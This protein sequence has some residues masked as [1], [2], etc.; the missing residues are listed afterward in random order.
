MGADVPGSTS[1]YSCKGPRAPRPH[2][3]GEEGRAINPY[4]HLG[5]GSAARA[6]GLLC[7][8]K[9]AVVNA[10]RSAA[11]VLLASNR[12]DIKGIKWAYMYEAI[13]GDIWDWPSAQ[14]LCFR[15]LVV[16]RSSTIDYHTHLRKPTKKTA[17]GLAR[18]ARHR[19]IA[20]A[21]FK[22]FL[23]SLERERRRASRALGQPEWGGYARPAL[24]RLRRGVGPEDIALLAVLKPTEKQA[25]RGEARMRA[26]EIEE[27]AARWAHSARLVKRLARERSMPAG[28]LG[29]GAAD[30]LPQGG[31]PSPAAAQ[32]RGFA[33]SH[34][35]P[36]PVVAYMWRN[37][38]R[39]CVLNAH[40]LLAYLLLR[41]NVT[42]RVTNFEEPVL[43]VA[44]MMG[45]ADIVI[46]MHGAGWTN[47]LFMKRG[48][49][50]MQLLPYGYVLPGGRAIRGA[51]YE[52]IALASDSIYVHWTNRR[53]RHAFMRRT[54]FA[55]L[56]RRG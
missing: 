33:Y 18:F 55:S 49:A 50:A 56:R 45:S 3:D 47:A 48:A 9:G 27:L 51:S 11:P 14:G 54:D 24:E 40:D 5:R 15:D 46:G 22:A 8:R 30:D 53:R 34:E 7:C 37:E 35:R 10:D 4:S 52:S 25:A 16:G 43:Q 2:L 42:V 21:A 20:T 38:F 39:R 1:A 28:A 13:S 29:A 36:R 23:L 32:P 44:E 26:G 17:E 19:S 6:G 12:T 31:G 41:Y